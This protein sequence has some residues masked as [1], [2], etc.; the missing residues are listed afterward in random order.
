M[1]S[2]RLEPELEARLKEAARI[3]G[4]P[5]SDIVRAAIWERCD[6][7]LEGRLDARLADVIG[8]AASGGGDS[9]KTGQS[10]VEALEAR[11]APKP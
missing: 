6:R 11:R 3:T 1:R 7:L 5:I 4:E 9:R 2:V 8:S 10:F